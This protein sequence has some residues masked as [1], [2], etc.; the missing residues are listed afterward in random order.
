MFLPISHDKMTVRRMPVVTIV[1]ILL[2]VASHVFVTLASREKE[3]EAMRALVTARSMYVEHPELGTCKPLEPFEGLALPP[4]VGVDLATSREYQRACSE[5]DA[6]ISQIPAQQLGYVPARAKWFTLFTYVFLHADVLHLV[7]NMWFLFLCGMALED[8]WG[9]LAFPVYYLVAGALAAGAQHLASPNSDRPIIGA[10]GA[11]AGAMGAFLVL[12]ATSRIRFVGAI[13]IRGLTFTA[14][15]YVMLPLWL[16][17]E[18]LLGLV[19]RD[20]HTAHWAHVGGFVFGVAV[21]GVF[22]IAGVDRRLDDAVEKAA[23][24]GDDPRVD[25]ARELVAKGAAK[26]ARAMLEGLAKE[27]PESIHVWEALHDAA[28]ACGDTTTAERAAAKAT[29][30]AAAKG[31]ASAVRAS[32]TRASEP[33]VARASTP[34]A[35]TSAGA[36]SPTAP[37]DASST[38]SPDASSTA[39][40]D[41]APFFPTVETKKGPTR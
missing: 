40:S 39:S 37:A 1:V 6:A 7:G 12:Y 13:G 28:V 18:T 25:E 2:T 16:G 5:L 38:A 41:D 29:A 20:A 3:A 32:E 21:A 27:K 36:T 33:S 30:L 26:Q 9:R 34:K 14:P 24:L 8:R 15:A 4:S 22:R 23:V 19:A 31:R 35:S 10:S 11:V 17:I